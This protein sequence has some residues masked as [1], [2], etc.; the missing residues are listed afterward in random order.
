MEAP[1]KRCFEI[2]HS[3]NELEIIDP[4]SQLRKLSS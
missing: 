3:Y 4:I 2:P 1:F